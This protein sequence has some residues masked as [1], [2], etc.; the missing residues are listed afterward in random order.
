M[1]EQPE[2]LFHDMEQNITS[3]GRWPKHPDQATY[4]RE[5]LV[6]KD[7]SVMLTEIVRLT[8]QLDEAAAK[9]RARIVAKIRDIATRFEPGSASQNNHQALARAIESGRAFAEGNPQ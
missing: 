6:H 5:D 4:L 9:E 8:D 1:S 3:Y 7:T 2:W